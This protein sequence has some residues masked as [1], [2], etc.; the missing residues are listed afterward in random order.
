M[1]ACRTLAEEL[2]ELRFP[3]PR[4]LAFKVLFP[5]ISP[6]ILLTV[7]CF[8]FILL[9]IRQKKEPNDLVLLQEGSSQARYFASRLIPAHK[10]PPYEQVREKNNG[11]ASLLLVLTGLSVS[12]CIYWKMKDC[13]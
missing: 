1:A 5:L 6:N 3:A 4:I 8:V 10:D 11:Q 7:H 12:V 13:I 2:T 9:A